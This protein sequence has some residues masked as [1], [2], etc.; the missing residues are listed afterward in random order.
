M[1]EKSEA[2]QKS[3]TENFISRIHGREAE[4]KS[5]YVETNDSVR[6]IVE[7]IRETNF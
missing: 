1:D 2:K 6:F 7:Q 5:Q 3:L 4:V